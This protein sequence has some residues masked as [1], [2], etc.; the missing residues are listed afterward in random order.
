MQETTLKDKK[1]C[2][3]RGTD[4]DNAGNYL[5]GEHSEEIDRQKG[6]MPNKLLSEL[7]QK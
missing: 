6:I 1:L 3:L 2:Q 5:S 4:Y 7:G